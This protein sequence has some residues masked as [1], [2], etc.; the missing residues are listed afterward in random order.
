MANRNEQIRKHAEANAKYLKG[1][2][3]VKNLRE[4]RHKGKW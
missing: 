3:I 4:M 1:V 2:D